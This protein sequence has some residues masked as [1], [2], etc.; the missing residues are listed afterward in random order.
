[1]IF[2][3]DMATKAITDLQV[4]ALTKKPGKHRIAP[5]LYLRV[6]DTGA[7]FWV[8]IYTIGGK[9]REAG[10]GRYPDVSLLEA[11]S[12]AAEMRL[13]IKRDGIDPLERKAAPPAPAVVTFRQVAADVIKAKRPGWRNPKHAQQWENTLAS[14]AFPIIGDM[15]VA[16]IDTEHVLAVLQPIWTSKHETATRLRQR[17]EAV[18]DAAAARKLRSRE[19]PARWRGHLDSLL[20]AISK[21][22]RVRHHPALPWR[23]LPAFMAQLRGNGS[24]SALALQFT[25]LTACRTG[26]VLGAQWQE[27]D[28]EQAVWVIPAAR[29]K[30]KREH[31]VPLPRQAVELLRALPRFEWSPYI[32]PGAKRGRPLS[33]MAMLQLVRGMRPGLTVHGFRSTFRDWISEATNFSPELAEQAL[34]HT[35]GNATEAAY[36]RGDLLERRR[37]M[38][39]AWADFCHSTESGARIIPL[40]TLGGQT[41]RPLS[42]H[43]G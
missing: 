8:L 20:S 38:M 15:D 3:D 21:A 29:M 39:Q 16:T 18:L 14:Y 6:R 25:I 26:E 2:G 27:V 41:R 4:K 31:R 9:S 19:N 7:A 37:A 34:A 40:P 12:R 1:M 28:L 36:R 42:I 33:Q 24:S 43:Q 30:A 32:F 11:T 35:I 10:L 22:D 23:E 5:G 17:I 13:Q